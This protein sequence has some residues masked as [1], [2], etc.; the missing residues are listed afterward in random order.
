MPK[1]ETVRFGSSRS[2]LRMVSPVFKRFDLCRVSS[3]LPLLFSSLSLP[4]QLVC[5]ESPRKISLGL[6]GTWQPGAEIQAQNLGVLV[7]SYR[8]PGVALRRSSNFAGRPTAV[9]EIGAGLWVAFAATALNFVTGSP[10]RSFCGCRG[11]AVAGDAQ[12]RPPW[13]WHPMP[14]K[15]M[16]WA[17]G[18]SLA[19]LHPARDA[20]C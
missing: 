2:S 4:C 5:L 6:P 16:L 9:S 15:E 20:A 13:T 17:W 12:H 11:T 7:S 18:W 10:V 1:P 14:D 19:Q 3:V 8:S